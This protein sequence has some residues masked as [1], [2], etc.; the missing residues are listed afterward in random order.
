MV[1]VAG[2][3]LTVTTV[4]AEVAEQPPEVTVTVYEPDVVA[5]I[6][7]VLAPPG[8]HVF[9]EAAEEVKVTDPPAQKVVEP[10]AVIVGVG[11]TGFTVTET[12]F[13]FGEVH[14]PSSKC[15]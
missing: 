6:L 11:G 2:A 14:D 3:A 8:V 5:E 4:G 7:C 9:P 12:V 13:E 1:G 15:T 10:P